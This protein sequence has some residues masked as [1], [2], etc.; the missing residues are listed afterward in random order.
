MVEVL[1]GVHVIDLS[2]EGGLPLECYLLNC[3]EGVVLIDTGMLPSAIERIEAELR[4]MGKK[5][6]DIKVCLITHRHGDHIRNLAR[7]KELSGAEVMAHEGDVGEIEKA[8]GVEVKGLKHG[9]RLPYCGGIEVVHVPGHSEGNCCYYLPERRLMI[10]GDTLFADE[11]GVLSPPPERYCL[12]VEQAKHEIKR[13]LDYDF[14][15]LLVTHGRNTMR[16]AREKVRE[17]CEKIG[18]A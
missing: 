9:E 17:L 2:E 18:V 5:W 8:T 10:A 11:K 6:D 7:V 4:A 13:L 3:D 15:V 1:K 12:D 16:D 14:D